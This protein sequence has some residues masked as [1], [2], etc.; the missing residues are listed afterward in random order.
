MGHAYSF[1][2]SGREPWGRVY[3][4]NMIVSS[5]TMHNCKVWCRTNY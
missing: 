4:S 2:N 3:C 5:M 1:M